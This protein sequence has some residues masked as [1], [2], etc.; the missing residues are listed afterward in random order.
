M[1]KSDLILMSLIQKKLWMRQFYL[2][3]SVQIDNSFDPTDVIGYFGVNSVFAAFTTPFT[4]AGDPEN[5]PA[6]ANRTK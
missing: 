2:Y 3:A 4:E 1:R 5:G 6:V